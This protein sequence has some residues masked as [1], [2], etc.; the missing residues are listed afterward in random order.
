MR[1]FYALLVSCG[2]F[3]TACS[4]PQRL[5]DGASAPSRPPSSRTAPPAGGALH[6]ELILGMLDQ[7]QYYAA[8]AHVQE[9]QNQFGKT[10]ELRWLEAESRR[11]LGMDR[12]AE[13][14]YRSLLRTDYAAQSHRG[15]GLLLAKTDLARAVEQLQ[16]AVQRRPSDALMRNDLGYALMMAG[17]YQEALPQLATAVELDPGGV[18]GLNNLVLLLLLTRD[19]TRAHSVA[20]EGGMS[21]AAMADLRRQA[22]VLRSKTPRP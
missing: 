8:L 1:L 6:K 22:Q 7:G 9:Q 12:I 19:E 4:L 11:H 2:A 14:L 21:P 16:Q 20:V 17:R 5:D 3:L 13:T 15:L 10:A 18:K